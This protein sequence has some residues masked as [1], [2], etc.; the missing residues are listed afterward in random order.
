MNQEQGARG[1]DDESVLAPVGPDGHDDTASHEMESKD[2]GWL[3]E[4]LAAGE[5]R[6]AI[7][8]SD[9]ARRRYLSAFVT[10]TP[11]PA[12]DVMLV[13]LAP[14]DEPVEFARPALLLTDDVAPAAAPY[15][16]GV[17]P[18]DAPAGQVMA[19]LAAVAHGLDVRPRA[20]GPP[21]LADPVR[22]VLTR[23]EFEILVLVGDGQSNKVVA[24]SLGISAHTVKYHLEAVFLKLGVRTRAEAVNIGLRRG[25]ARV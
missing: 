13:D 5:P 6:V 8:A 9:P 23:R 15:A 18:R 2:G 24:R 7:I 4:A 22:P 25:L 11:L 3:R 10:E 19:A 1:R 14:G 17:L 16:A 21:M 12:S 20:S